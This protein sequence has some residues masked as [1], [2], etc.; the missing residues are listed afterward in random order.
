MIQDLLVTARLAFHAGLISDL[1]RFSMALGGF[2]PITDWMIEGIS[3]A[4]Y[5]VGHLFIRR[6]IEID[7]SIDS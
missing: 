7:G 6:K 2:R 5:G 1:L 4:L 3:I